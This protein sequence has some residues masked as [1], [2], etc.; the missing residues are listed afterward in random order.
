M[1]LALAP[2]ALLAVPQQV[3][4]V[5]AQGGGNFTDLP[6]AVAAASS[7]DVL[8]VREGDYS[9]FQTSGVALSI[10][11]HPAAIEAP[12]ILGSV[13][14]TQVPLGETFLLDGFEVEAFDQQ[15]PVLV[16]LNPGSIRIQDC[17]LKAHP[18]QF[19]DFPA[20]GMFA[21]T[22]DD[23]AVADSTL[24]GGDMLAFLGYAGGETGGT[25]G[26]GITINQAQVAV[27]RSILRGGEGG[28]LPNG[29]I[30]GQGGPGA[31]IFGGRLH[32]SQCFLRA[33]QSGDTGDGIFPGLC[34]NGGPGLSVLSTNSRV[35]QLGTTIVGGDPG[36]YITAPCT[37]GGQIGP[38]VSGDL[39]TI[40]GV[41]RALIVDGVVLEG[42]PVTTRYRGKPG[43]LAA[44]LVST[45]S[46]FL[47]RPVRKGALLID[48]Q[49]PQSILIQGTLDGEGT[50]EVTE[51]FGLPAGV[52]ASTLYLQG[53]FVGVDG[54]TN[55]ANPRAMTIVR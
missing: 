23:V 12:R 18:T 31:T 35:S 24:E 8:L 52:Q 37:I 39:R 48:T 53:L 16:T 34:A 51:T 14:L 5:D 11:A 26:A 44:R 54:V 30:G 36:A 1:L 10:Q 7:G 33:G 15:V 19:G 25:G 6:A 27:H 40:P 38:A 4:I 21:Q 3:L 43:D 22:S 49:L 29:G 41:P 47:W 17:L 45:S 32:L 46:A 42:T 2:L 13:R 55:L 9:G 20:S 50:L 28:D